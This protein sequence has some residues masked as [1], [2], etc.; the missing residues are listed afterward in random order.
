MA[1]LLH[2]LVAALGVAALVTLSAPAQA[3]VRTCVTVEP[4]REDGAAL[5]RLVESEVNRHPSHEVVDTDC[6]SYLTVELIEVGA[7]RYV[8]ARVGVEV[9]HREP[10]TAA[11]IAPAL[12]RA[13]AIVLHSDPR[14]LS[15][16]ER[17]QG[18][19]HTA[20]ELEQRGKNHFGVELFELCAVVGG[21]VNTLPGIAAT[22]RREVGRFHVGARIAGAFGVPPQGPAL[23][24]S[25]DLT[26]ALDATLYSSSTAGTAAFASVLLG[27][28]HQRFYGRRR[29]VEG[30]S[31]GTALELGPSA[32][33]RGGVELFRF[34][35]VR[36][37]GFVQGSLPLFASRDRDYGVVAQYM[38]SLAVGVGAVF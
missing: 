28:E 20:R 36:Y 24:L 27:L 8:T 18:M 35:S 7:E 6:E 3:R 2:T 32:G 16:P 29:F 23:H 38:P 13:L 33:L 4:G 30:E 11:G 37:L 21:D 1:R 5:R 22:A 10:V 14:T 25:A 12:E 17:D 34:A 15:G 31:Y 19:F 26:A 9:P